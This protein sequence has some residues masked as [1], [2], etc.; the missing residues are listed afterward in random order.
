MLPSAIRGFPLRGCTHRCIAGNSF[1]ALVAKTPE[2]NIG[3]GGKWWVGIQLPRL[4]RCMPFPFCKMREVQSAQIGFA[5]CSDHM[6]GVQHSSIVTLYAKL[7]TAALLA[8]AL[9]PWWTKCWKTAGAASGE[10]LIQSLVLWG[11]ALCVACASG[12]RLQFMYMLER[13]QAALTQNRYVKCCIGADVS[14]P[15]TTAY[16]V[17]QHSPLAT[18]DIPLCASRWLPNGVPTLLLSGACNVM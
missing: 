5:S 18:S 4:Q 13:V 12:E 17:F 15:T 9:Q 16:A 1:A 6:Y 3:W 8:T 10:L 14:G 2:N 7:C 11:T